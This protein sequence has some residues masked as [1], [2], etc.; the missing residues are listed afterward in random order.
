M[1]YLSPSRWRLAV[2]IVLILKVT[3]CDDYTNKKL[4]LRIVS[5]SSK[6]FHYLGRCPLFQCV[7]QLAFAGPWSEVSRSHRCVFHGLRIS[8][9]VVQRSLKCCYSKVWNILLVFSNVT[10]MPHAEVRFF[11]HFS[12]P[13]VITSQPEVTTFW[14]R[15]G[16][17]GD[18]NSL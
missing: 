15:L 18:K 1:R 2:N 13:E 8:I 14:Y 11:T 10:L 16:L 5:F 4:S 7:S 12:G 9:Y 3:S 17:F 6:L